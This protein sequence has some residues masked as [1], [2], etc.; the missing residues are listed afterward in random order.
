MSTEYGITAK[1]FSVKPFAVIVKEI[2]DSIKARLGNDILFIPEDPL[3]EI[4]EAMAE[5][6]YSLWMQ[7]L[8]ITNS[9]YISK[10]SGVSL[11]YAVA[12]VNIRRNPALK[13][14]VL[15]QAFWGTVG[16]SVPIGTGVSVDTDTTLLWVTQSA[17]PLGAGSNANYTVNEIVGLTDGSF[18]IALLGQQTVSLAWNATATQV[19]NAINSLYGVYDCTVD[20]TG[21]GIWFTF[22]FTL[23][24]IDTLTIVD[25][26]LTVD[27]ATAVPVIT[28]VA[29]GAYQ[30]IGLVQAEDAGEQPANIYAISSVV[31]QSGTNVA[32]TLNLSDASAGANIESDASLRDRGLY[33]YQIIKFGTFEGIKSTLDGSEYLDSNSIINN[34]SSNTLFG[35]TPNEIPPNSFKTFLFPKQQLTTE[36]EKEIATDIFL[37]KPIG[38]EAV[39]DIQYDIIDS[40]GHPQAVGISYAD[41][42]PI[43]LIL[44]LTTNSAYPTDG[45]TALKE[46]LV[47]WGNALGAGL[48]IVI[49][50]TDS[51]CGQIS[52]F[53]GIDDMLV[54]IGKVTP[55]TTDANVAIDNGTNTGDVEVSAWDVA[56]ITINYT[57]P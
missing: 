52:L 40:E 31:E 42:I 38:I 4:V 49:H 32:A 48:D 28:T 10:A 57:T 22:D 5:R 55:P 16:T 14:F 20:A 29:V 36:Q 11:D 15:Q 41:A 21:G 12:M 1:G 9:A 50:G 3:N 39:G 27:G 13:G 8:D 47:E 35:G 45:S 18:K 44:T 2:Q 34:D 26:S 25:S 6:E 33:G 37:T 24:N 51:L 19:E 53:P 43:Y 56:N 30:G 17:I 7:Q 23:Q 46:Q 54:K